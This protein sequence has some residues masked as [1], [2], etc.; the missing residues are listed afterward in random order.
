MEKVKKVMKIENCSKMARFSSNK[1]FCNLIKF[2]RKFCFSYFISETS[3]FRSFELQRIFSQEL[4]E[5]KS[6]LYATSMLK[7]FC[8]QESILVSRIQSSFFQEKI[9]NYIF[10]KG[11]D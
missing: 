3:I 5:L 8:L 10:C 2:P 1:T 6:V 11:S 9:S 7:N 4:T